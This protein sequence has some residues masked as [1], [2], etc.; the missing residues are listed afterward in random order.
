MHINM[1]N[2]YLGV[3]IIDKCRSFRIQ[4]NPSSGMG[5]GT[6]LV[7]DATGGPAVS[8][9]ISPNGPGKPNGPTAQ[10]AQTAQAICPSHSRGFFVPERLAHTISIGQLKNTISESLSYSIEG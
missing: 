1:K 6:R 10:T 4:S 7:V 9:V 3:L 8:I 2:S 5:M